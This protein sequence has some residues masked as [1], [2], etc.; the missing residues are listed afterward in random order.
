MKMMDV[1]DCARVIPRGVE[2]NKDIITDSAL[3]H[4]FWSLYRPNLAIIDALMRKGAS[5]MRAL[6]IKS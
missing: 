3:T 5:D 1:N 4:L 2:R 6:R